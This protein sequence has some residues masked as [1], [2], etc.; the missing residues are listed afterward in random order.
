MRVAVLDKELRVASKAR[1]SKLRRAPIELRATL[2][3]EMQARS[4]TLAPG[5]ACPV[6][7]RSVSLSQC[8]ARAPA[9]ARAD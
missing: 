8:G 9:G 2:A 7:S 6:L 4:Q 3:F 1:E 5:A